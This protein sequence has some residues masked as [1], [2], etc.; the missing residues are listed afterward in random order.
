MFAEN[1]AAFLDLAGFAIAVTYNGV[2]VKGIFDNGY[3]A[4]LDVSSVKPTCLCDV[5]DVSGNKGDTLIK[6]G[7]TYK[8]VDSEPDGTGFIQLILERQ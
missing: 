4:G 6:D 5:D 7:V 3:Y 8:V 2:R 1:R